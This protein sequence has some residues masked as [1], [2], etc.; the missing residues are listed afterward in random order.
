[1]SRRF[2]VPTIGRYELLGVLGRGSTGVVFE[3]RPAGDRA[4]SRPESGCDRARSALQPAVALKLVHHGCRDAFERE[5]RALTALAGT[6]GVPRLLDHGTCTHGS[7]LVTE[8][9]TGRSLQQWLECC[10]PPPPDLLVDL[11]ARLLAVIQSIHAAGYIHADVKPA[12]VLLDSG[13]R[14]VL[15]DLG[16]AAAQAH[17]PSGWRRP[18]DGR[19]RPVTGTTAHLAPEVLAGSHP[20]PA[21]DLYGAGS[22]L[23]TLLAGSP[24]FGTGNGTTD[25]VFA[26]RILDRPPPEPS[27]LGLP[28]PLRDLVV[29]LLDKEP[30]CRRM[31]VARYGS[32]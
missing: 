7:Y 11:A 23:W 8:S 12:N 24:P 28:A 21:G 13:R 18:L 22:I 20:T 27:R 1:M 6:A 31:A 9:V 26:Q 3:A 10:G 32:Q 2:R 29:G 30:G 5:H 15:I 17:R 16:G 19:R 14:P 4:R 25:H